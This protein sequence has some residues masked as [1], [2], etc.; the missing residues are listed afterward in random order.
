MVPSLEHEDEISAETKNES[1]L[2]ATF[3][4]ENVEVRINKYPHEFQAFWQT[5]CGA[6][7]FVNALREVL[8]FPVH[9]ITIRYSYSHDCEHEN[10]FKQQYT[11]DSAQKFAEVTENLEFQDLDFFLIDISS[12]E[13]YW[14]IEE[15]MDGSKSELIHIYSPSKQTGLFQILFPLTAPE[16]ADDEAIG[17]IY[18]DVIEYIDQSATSNNV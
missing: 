17:T 14:T 16:D 7:R 18:H 6:E 9:D 10:S 3:S 2:E 15:F 5:D 1:F 4:E 8:A 12:A 13:V 11:D